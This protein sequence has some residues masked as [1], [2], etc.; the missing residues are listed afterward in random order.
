MSGFLPAHHSR[1][2]P[3]P[4]ISGNDAEVDE[5]VSEPG[6][7]G[8]DSQIASEGE[9]EACPDCGS[10]DGGDGDKVG[11]CQGSGETLDRASVGFGNLVG[12]A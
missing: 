2:N 3:G 1:K 4:A 6:V 10:V 9:V 7:G 5:G 11:A 12:G 8:A